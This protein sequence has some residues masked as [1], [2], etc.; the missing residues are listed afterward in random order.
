MQAPMPVL[1]ASLPS[2]VPPVANMFDVLNDDRYRA[3]A[4]DD[5]E[6]ATLPGATGGGDCYAEEHKPVQN[7]QLHP[8]LKPA[9]NSGSIPAGHTAPYTL[10]R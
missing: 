10:P 3:Y 5:V 1:F 8:F 4:E 2:C 7:G 6:F 9:G